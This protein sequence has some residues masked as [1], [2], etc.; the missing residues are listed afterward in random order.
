MAVVPNDAAIR[1]ADQGQSPATDRAATANDEA[2]RDVQ[3][4]L[5]DLPEP[6]EATAA[7]D[8]LVARVV[9]NRPVD[10]TFEYRVPQPL[11][12]LVQ[13]GSRVMVPFGRGTGR[14]NASVRAHVVAVSETPSTNR[15]LKEIA[16]VLDRTPLID[17]AM[18]QLTRWI[19]DRYLCSWG[20]VLDSVI[21]AGVRKQAG[22]REVLR[23]TLTDVGRRA[24][25]EGQRLPKKQ[26]AVVA[27]LAAAEGPLDVPTLTTAADCGPGPIRSLVDKQLVAPQRR[28]ETV[29]DSEASLASA[30]SMPHELRE[31]ELTLSDDQRKALDRTLAAIRSGEHSTLLLH[32]V[33]GSGKTEV[34]MRAIAEVVSYGRQAIVLVPEIALTPQTI[35]R[36]ATRFDRVAVLHSH[37]TDVQRH[38][39]WQQIAS[40]RV[41]VVVGARSAI[42]APVPHLGLVVI[43]EEHE[44]TFKQSTTPRYHAREVARERTRLA[45]VPLVLG[46]ATPTLE[47]IRAARDLGDEYISMPARV[48]AR[49]LPPVS[50]V[51][52]R[53]D[54]HVARGMSLGRAVR[55]AMQA[56]LD[57]RGQI[58]LFLNLRGYSPLLWC[59]KCDKAVEC[60][61]CSTT[62]TWHRQGD[63][64][65]RATQ[66]EVR[67]HTCEHI[68]TAP[69][70]CPSCEDAVPKRL[71]TGTQRLER[72]VAAT[73]PRATI[74]RMDSDSMSQRGAHDETLSAFGEG[75]IDILLGT[76][77]IAKGLDFP[78]VTLVGVVDADTMLNQPDLRAAERTFHL[79]SQV[80]G[81]TGRGE[82]GGRVLV[83]TRRPDDPV[84][85]LVAAHDFKR[86]ARLELGS[87]RAAG[88]PPFAALARLVVRGPDEAAT[89]RAAREIAQRLTE[90]IDRITA[91]H[92]ATQDD[93]HK[94]SDA[95]DRPDQ[96]PTMQ[97][98]GPAPAPLTRLRDLWRFHLQISGPTIESLRDLWRRVESDVQ[99]AEPI[100]LS[101]DVDPLDM[102]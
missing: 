21:P 33:T 59:P 3:A 49:Q 6:W 10:R 13:P 7:D 82:K 90:E 38:Q 69:E 24:L 93:A 87:R 17:A 63:A 74:A 34:Y 52:I 88:A 39:Q 58:I 27:A 26:A 75:K 65:T 97:V 80:A 101:I 81:R 19:A 68:S 43:D 45:G 41:P 62:L 71:G 4:A 42:F 32:G 95:A 73:F 54:P 28:R 8:R 96:P 76:Q 2:D 14:R 57:D 22:T 86:F 25:R 51:D 30:S 100:E 29:F 89:L 78:N 46:S 31:S 84:I 94:A 83:Q 61:H 72:E 91:E 18:L 79:I 66:G 20:Q 44:T 15:P 60:P 77:M 40:G 48:S 99:P 9:V 37:L 50:I 11:R 102:R 56:A 70:R 16:E 36:F 53:D 35:R 12:P 1:R 47:S 64:K 98:V 55:L 85:Q 5:F 67:C 23:Y 92:A